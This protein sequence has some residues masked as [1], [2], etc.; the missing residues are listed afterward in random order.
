MAL[1]ELIEVSKSYDVGETV[2]P[3]HNLS[4]TVPEGTMISIQGES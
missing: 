2:Y 1:C 4:F 3:I